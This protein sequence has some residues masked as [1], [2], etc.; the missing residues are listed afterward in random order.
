MSNTNKG[1]ITE[2]SPYT[3]LEENFFLSGVLNKTLFCSISG[4]TSIFMV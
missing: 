2:S 4:F 1:E 3:F